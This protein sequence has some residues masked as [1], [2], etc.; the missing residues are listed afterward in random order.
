MTAASPWDMPWSET[1]MTVV[2]MSRQRVEC[3]EQARVGLGAARRRDPG[4]SP[5]VDRDREL[6]TRIVDGVLATARAD[7]GARLSER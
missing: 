1:R 7:R 6:E 2:R 3:A 4:S 5:R